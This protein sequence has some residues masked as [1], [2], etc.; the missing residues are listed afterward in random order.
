MLERHNLE[1][2]CFIAFSASASGSFVNDPAGD[3]AFTMHFDRVLL[4]SIWEVSALFEKDSL[5][6]AGK[7]VSRS[8][9]WRMCSCSHSAE[10]EICA[11]SMTE[12]KSTK[13]GLRGR[14]QRRTVFEIGSQD[15][16]ICW[17]VRT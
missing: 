15:S 6:Y 12:Q 13:D 17:A 14:E 8:L 2:R 3:L 10:G 4:F 11:I 1:F 7:A 16:L 5:A 9:S